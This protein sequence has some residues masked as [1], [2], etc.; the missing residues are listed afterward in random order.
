[1]SD[2]KTH[3]VKDMLRKTIPFEF[4][5]D[6]LMPLDIKIRQM[7]GV[8][9][10]YLDRKIVLVLRLRDDHTDSNGVWIATSEEHHKSLKIEFPSLRPISYFSEATGESEWQ[11]LPVGA[12]DFE[13]SVRKIC[14]LIKHNDIRIGRF[15]GQ[16]KKQK[17]MLK[18]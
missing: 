2:E 10:I 4:V 16:K 9:A 6:Y 13:T 14:E 12:E 15:P 18:G 7:F 17:K 3:E 1:M 8:W 11:V 5:L